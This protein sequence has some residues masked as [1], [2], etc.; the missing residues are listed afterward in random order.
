MNQ[1]SLNKVAI[2]GASGGVGIALIN[3][4]LSEN[5]RILIFQRKGSERTKNIPNSPMIE[6]VECN[7]NELRKYIPKERDYDVFFHLGWTNTN[8]ELRNCLEAQEENVAYS[9]HAVQLAH[10]L[11]CH[12]F[13]GAGSQAEYGRCNVP[14]RGD[15]V[16]KPETAYGIMKLCACH[17]TDILCEE[18]GIRHIWARILSGYGSYDNENSMLISTI[19]NSLEGKPLLFTKGEQVWDFVHLDDIANALFLL[20]KS[21]KSKGIY[22]I[23]SGKARKL[24]SY[25]EILCDKLGKLQVAQFGSIPY[26]SKEI[27]HLEADISKIQNDTG[28]VPEIDFEEGIDNTI[29]FYSARSNR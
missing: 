6:V 10:K 25:I 24:R 17:S 4:L 22:P 16:C 3:K 1:Y 2:T 13:I 29:K 12:T 14:L 26:S 19:I 9:C 28:W 21:E 15:T 11:G 20:A 23:G 7:L 27:M 8:K 18:L 5:I